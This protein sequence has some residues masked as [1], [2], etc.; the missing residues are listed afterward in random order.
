MSTVE[1]TAR[2]KNSNQP[3]RDHKCILKE[4]LNFIM[5]NTLVGPKCLLDLLFQE[6]ILSK[7]EHED[8]RCILERHGEMKAVSALITDV[9]IFC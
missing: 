4:N 6:N 3:E 7:S 9:C 5:Q 8:I 1:S 2:V